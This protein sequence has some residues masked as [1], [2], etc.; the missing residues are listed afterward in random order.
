MKYLILYLFPLSILSQNLKGKVYD[1]Q[2][3]VKGIKVYN[4][5]KQTKTYTD[6]IG[7]F[8][9]QASVNDTL[10]FESLFHHPKQVTIQQTDFESI[11]VFEL[12]KLV[13]E[14]GE[15]LLSSEK[16]KVFNPE[17][18]TNATGLQLANDIKNN[19]HLYKPESAYSGGAN[20]LGLVGMAI[21]L[22]KKKNKYKPKPIEYLSYKHLDSLFKNDDF[23]DLRLL[24]Q[25]L[26][27]PEEYAHL[28][29][30][31]CETKN[32]NKELI[33]EHHKV[34]LLDSLVEFSRAF[35]KITETFKTSKDSLLIKK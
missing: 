34:I 31:Y 13:N 29:L 22:F 19:P 7:E 33:S 25:D 4:I 1:H 14:L 12:K 2:A 10:L 24:N 9:M 28:F 11:T 27:I 30:D 8:S 16:N 20:I 35:L 6:D 18:Y 23:F 21:K 32:L 17:K 3:T 15:V 26:K 5:S